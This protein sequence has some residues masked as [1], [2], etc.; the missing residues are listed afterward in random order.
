MGCVIV[1][2]GGGISGLALAHWL[3]QR[4]SPFVL[5]ESRAQLGGNVGTVERDGFLLETG[6][7]A[8]LDREPA[9]RRLISELGLES[10]Q[11]VAEPAAKARWVFLKG[12]LRQAPSSPQSLLLGN[13]LPKRTLLRAAL[14]PLSRPPPGDDETLGDFTRRHFGSAAAPLMD[15]VQTGTYAGDLERL[16]AHAAF[17][18]LA[19]LERSHR[20]LL[21]A[22]ARKARAGGRPAKSALCTFKDGLG[23]LISALHRSVEK[24]VH[25]GAEVTALAKSGDGWNVATRSGASF[26]A[27]SVVLTTPAFRSAELLRPLD[28][29]LAAELDAIPYAPVAVVHLG[30]ARPPSRPGFGLIVPAAQRRPVL[31]VIFVS[32]L[33]PWRA[34]ADAAL[35][36]CIMGGALRP[37]VAAWPEEQLVGVAQDELRRL[38][39]VDAAPRLASVVRWPRGIPQYNV[40]HSARLARLDAALT[41]WPGL[42]LGGNA[43]RGVGVND[44]VRDAAA[45][46]EK[47]AEL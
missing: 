44:C 2:V 40:G 24:E 6:P 14:E 10:Q 3:K 32:S 25:T 41:R 18:Q 29:R 15:A 4:G 5:L 11:V 1:I 38:L 36:T 12:K 19:G 43:Y 30:F 23:T 46:A 31:G 35:Y 20:S 42:H 37:E 26:Q 47:L 8:F 28:G 39:G 22:M 33:F 9:M 17:P 21:V 13:F 7:N 16:S 45:M 34:P 27:S